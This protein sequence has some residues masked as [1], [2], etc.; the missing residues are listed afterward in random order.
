MEHIISKEQFKH[1]QQQFRAKAQA[2]QLTAADHILYNLVRGKPLSHGFTPLTNPGRL[3]ACQ[4]N[5]MY[6]YEQAIKAAEWC[7][8]IGGWSPS[9]YKSYFTTMFGVDA[10]LSI[11]Q[12][13]F[14]GASK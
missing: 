2:K 7:L 3:Q 10:N 11:V 8:Q 4:N 12:A 5:P 1:F 6:H 9:S 13:A 14:R